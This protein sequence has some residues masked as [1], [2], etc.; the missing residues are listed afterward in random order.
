MNNLDKPFSQACENNKTPILEV[1]R[2]AFRDRTRVLEIGSG[3]G[4]HA[5][6][7]AAELSHLEWQTSDLAENHPGIQL[8][9][10]EAQLPN[11]YPPIE[12]DV[13][14]R[15]WPQGFDAVF[16]ANTTH[17][18]P[19]EAVIE[20]IGRIGEALPEGGRFCQYGPFN[21]GGRYTSESN[22]RFDIWLKQVEPSQGIRD[23]EAVETLARQAG[24][25]L[26]ADHELPANNRLLEWI[27]RR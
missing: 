21:Y 4:Q 7:F 22:A 26:L 18:M 2:Q 11:L 15:H 12:L 8:W 16:T 19:W 1:L 20:M 14:Q 5:V 9:L 3:T 10:A 23:F 13:T 25:E 24:L 27:K 6:H 17:I